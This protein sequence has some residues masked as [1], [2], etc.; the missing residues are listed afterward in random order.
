MTMAY[1][2]VGSLR[3]ASTSGIR[4][5]PSAPA[6]RPG[7]TTTAVQADAKYT[8]REQAYDLLVRPGGVVSDSAGSRCRAPGLAMTALW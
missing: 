8:H 1:L 3:S 5:I 6:G 2:P 4:P 7:Y